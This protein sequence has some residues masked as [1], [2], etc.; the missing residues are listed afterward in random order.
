VTS[1]ARGGDRAGAAAGADAPRAGMLAAP[2]RRWRALPAIL[3]GALM[4]QF[5]L[6]VVNV[7]AP[8][9]QAG[10][11]TTTGMVQ[12]AV[13]GYSLTYGALLTAGG[14][15]GDVLGP[16]ALLRAGMLSFATASGVCALCQT[17]PQL[18]AA[19]L[20]QGACAAAMVPQVLALIT[21]LFPPA[22]RGK[23][24]AWFGVTLGLGAVLGQALGGFLVIHAP[25][26]LSWRMVFLVVVPVA[27]AG[28]CLVGRKVPADPPRTA[29]ARPGVDPAGLSGLSASLLLIFIAVTL[30]PV[31]HWP[32]WG[33][34]LMALGGLGMTVTVRWEIRRG[35]NE[36]PAVIDTALFRQ[37]VFQVGLGINSAY[38]LAFGGVLFVMT[39]T[40]QEGLHESAVLSGLTFVPQ[41]AAFAL[42]SLIGARIATRMGP[43]LV[44]V[45]ACAS[46]AACALLLMQADRPHVAVGPGHLW[47][48]MGLLG[49]GNG[50]AIPAMI[51]S[52]LKVVPHGTS[53]TAAGVLT[54]TQ[55]ISMAFGVA[56]LGSVQ[57][58]ATAHDPG[59]S[60]YLTGLRITLLLAAILLALAA[61]ASTS[62]YRRR[63]GRPDSGSRPVRRP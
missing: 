31:N 37:A 19:R 30:A 56:I 39:F 52:V 62:L 13:G 54:T 51:A 8:T 16:R 15:L 1:R 59:P 44:T 14:R 17:G 46:S 18:V 36:Q 35:R 25:W 45:G 29:L 63:S 33:W 24:T 41:G 55:Q 61:I 53:G 48:F 58:V 50:L 3:L 49:V 5:D 4:A 43:R 38:F 12:L 11:H 20:L 22:E 10:L 23:A 21:R 32:W 26:H 28:A 57:A 60:G 2:N 27:L 42:A 9:L 47:P 7:A 6:F 40:L 34:L